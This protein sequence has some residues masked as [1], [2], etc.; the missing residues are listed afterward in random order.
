MDALMIYVL[1]LKKDRKVSLA[2]VNHAFYTH[3]NAFPVS[4][5]LVNTMQCE[6]TVIQE[7]V[8]VSA[9]FRNTKANSHY[10]YFSNKNIFNSKM[11]IPVCRR[12][13]IFTRFFGAY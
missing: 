11:P 12:F 7:K 10:F 8:L 13:I 1:V 9:N 6:A 4:C 3:I 2:S 5:E